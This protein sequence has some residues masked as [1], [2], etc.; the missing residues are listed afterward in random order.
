[1]FFADDWHYTDGATSPDNAMIVSNRPGGKRRRGEDVSEDFWGNPTG[2]FLKITLKSGTPVKSK[3]WPWVQAAL[4]GVLGKEKVEKANFLRDGTLL[5]KTKNQAQTE[6]LLEVHSLLREECRV[7]RDTKLNV[8]KG[9]ILAH[10]LQE[11]SDEEI[12]QWLSEYGVTGAKRFVKKEGDKLVPTPTVLLTFDMPTC[13]QRITLDYVTY[14]VRRHI[15]NPLQCFKCG[16]FGH[17][18]DRCTNEKKCLTCGKSVHEGQCQPKCVNCGQT[19]HMCRFRDCPVWV[20]EKEICSLKVEN[21]ISYA[22]ARERYDSMQKPPT[23]HSYADVVRTPSEKEKQVD[24]DMKEK[25]EKLEKK[26]DHLSAILV[27]LTKKLGLAEEGQEFQHDQTRQ[28]QRVE[29]E[30]GPKERGSGG[31]TG[32]SPRTGTPAVVTAK[33]AKQPKPKPSKGPYKQKEKV[34]KEKGKDIDIEM[35]SMNDDN[36][37]QVLAR[38]SVSKE[39]HKPAP[40]TKKSWREDTES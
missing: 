6:K 40:T 32:L 18:Q 35:E 14:H 10:D 33:E 30:E 25:V 20:K 4:R 1:M 12:T 3:G 15:P 5:I 19:G 38:R 11:L 22:E 36:P 26:I 37:S 2:S 29:D 13:P 7:E 9:T 27:Q 34:G 28:E 17:H 39:R 21:E 24:C 16:K 8:S 23:L 31:G